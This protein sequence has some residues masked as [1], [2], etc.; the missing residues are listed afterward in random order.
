MIYEIAGKNVSL[1]ETKNYQDDRT[2][3]PSYLNESQGVVLSTGLSNRTSQH[4]LNRG[5]FLGSIVHAFEFTQGI[6]YLPTFP[7]TLN[8]QFNSISFKTSR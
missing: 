7:F 5:N 3:F 8:T 6:L 2:M 1:G 4:L